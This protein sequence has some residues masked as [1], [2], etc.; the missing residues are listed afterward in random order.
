MHLYMCMNLL[1][2]YISKGKSLPLMKREECWRDRKRSGQIGT[3]TF[4]ECT[5][6]L[7]VSSIC[8]LKKEKM[9][10]Q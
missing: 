4:Y 9:N 1:Y 8:S 7:S 6:S 10:M 3:S 5:F 2:G